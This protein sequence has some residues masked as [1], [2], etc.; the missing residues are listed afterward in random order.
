MGEDVGE[1]T[2][3]LQSPGIQEN[4]PVTGKRQGATLFVPQ[5]D[6][7][8]VVGQDA[9]PEKARKQCDCNSSRARLFRMMYMYFVLHLAGNTGIDVLIRIIDIPRW[10]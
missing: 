6:E 3:V 8:Q 10:D 5:S 2:R 7:R 4:H 1:D 9:D